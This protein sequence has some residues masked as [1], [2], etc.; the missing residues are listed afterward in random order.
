M[1]KCRV[2]DERHQ[3]CDYLGSVTW[4][5]QLVK[6]K[7]LSKFCSNV[8]NHYS[9]RSNYKMYFFT[10]S[11]VSN[12]CCCV[13]LIHMKFLFVL[14]LSEYTYDFIL[15]NKYRVVCCQLFDQRFPVAFLV[16]DTIVSKLLNVSE[17][18]VI[19]SVVYGIRPI[20]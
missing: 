13:F 2:P 5:D 4:M 8:L 10:M 17:D 9:M 7:K 11:Y 12:P 16:I 14:I 6:K 19:V 15:T 3:V 20:K 1:Y 18:P